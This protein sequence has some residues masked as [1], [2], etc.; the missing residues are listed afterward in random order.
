[1]PEVPEESLGKR[2]IKVALKLL[3]LIVS[4]PVEVLALKYTVVIPCQMFIVNV[5]EGIG[6]LLLGVLGAM[7]VFLGLSLVI[8]IAMAAI[9]M[10]LCIDE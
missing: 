9:M 8:G 1:V 6:K 3:I 5:A 10:W 7:I 4:I 2:I